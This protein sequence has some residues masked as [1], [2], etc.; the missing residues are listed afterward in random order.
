MCITN[1]QYA[2]DKLT[3]LNTFP[4]H[5]LLFSSTYTQ[6]LTVVNYHVTSVLY[7]VCVSTERYKGLS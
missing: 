1:G 5:F 2:D 4:K 6:S 7:T 3:L